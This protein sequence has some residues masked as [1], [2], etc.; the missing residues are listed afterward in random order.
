MPVDRV[1]SEIDSNLNASLRA[2]ELEPNLA[3]GYFSL[4]MSRLVRGEFVEA[5][6]AYRKG[7]ELAYDPIYP[8]NYGLD[9]HSIAVG[10]FKRAY[11]IVEAARQIDPLKQDIRGRYILS[12]GLRDDMQRAEDEYDNGG[13]L[14]GDHWFWGD[15]FLT[16]TRLGTKDVVSRDEIIFPGP[17][18][19][20]AKEHVDSPEEGLAVLHQFYSN[21]GNLSENDITNISVWA[22]Y[23]G[24]PKFAMDAMEK[25]IRIN[26]TGLFKIWL[27]VMH[28]VRQLPRFKEFAKEIGLVDYWNKFS[29]PDI[30]H[31][32]GDDDFVCD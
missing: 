31:P 26:A 4:G 27:P 28:E 10:Y 18:H 1:A 29:W 3:E 20:A 16:L 13:A 6:L 14:F 23:F 9:M 12:F 7:M 22:A 11:E 5:E 25:G 21:E 19:D 17:I 32:V 2:T 15:L 8:F 24:D 30:C